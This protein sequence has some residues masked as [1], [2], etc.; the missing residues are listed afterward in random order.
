MDTDVY[1]YSPSV[2]L[3]TVDKMAMI[4]QSARTIARVFGMFGLAPWQ[5]VGTD[6]DGRPKPGSG[7]LAHPNNDAEFRRGPDASD[8][9]RLWPV[10]ENGAKISS[11]LSPPCSFKTRLTS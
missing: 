8:C 3:G 7:R 2:L 9:R 1:A 11:T 5:Y 6:G 10:Y 4:G